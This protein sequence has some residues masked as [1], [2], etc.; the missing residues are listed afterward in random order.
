LAS[1]L[2]VP[3]GF[4]NSTSGNIKIALDAI[5]SSS[6]P[7]NFLGIDTLGKASIIQTLG[8]KN[9]H[10]ILRGSSDKPNYFIE[11][12][13]ET[14]YEMHKRNIT[15]NIMIDCSHGNSQKSHKNQ[16]TIVKYLSNI[17]KS[18]NNNI[19]GLMIESN[20]Y[21]GNQKL[22]TKEELKYGISITDSCLDFENSI[23]C[24]DIISNSLIYKKNNYKLTT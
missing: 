15:P 9:C 23:I 14:S 4:K 2:S 12:I 11:N 24:L 16:I 19:C 21:E 18:G 1:G 3:I 17:I 20:I 22:K 13:I 8:N 6:E 10:I 5:Q 7:H